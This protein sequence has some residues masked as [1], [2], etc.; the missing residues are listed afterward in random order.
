MRLTILKLLAI[1]LTTVFTCN[2]SWALKSDQSQPINVTS[3]EQSADLQANKL[4]FSGDVQATQGTIKL[5]AN[6]V[7]VTRNSNGTLKSIVA[8]GNPVKFEQQQD[9]G[10]YLK[11]NASTLSYFPDET[12]IVL[13]GR[14]TIWQGESK[15]SGERI[16]Y[17]INTQKMRAVNNNAQGGRV[18]STFVPSDFAKEQKKN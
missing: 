13:N 18:S 17:N 6:K 14:A 16:E 15:M 4:L 1:S 12:R 8:Y 11:A 2:T 10:R 7:E 9:N 3:L 5:N